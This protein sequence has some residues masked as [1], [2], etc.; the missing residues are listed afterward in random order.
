MPDQPPLAPLSLF[1]LVLFGLLLVFFVI[2]WTAL[3]SGGDARPPAR[4]READEA[5]P[6]AGAAP[7]RQAP[8][9]AK[10]AP[11]APAATVRDNAR[12]TADSDSVVSYSVRPRLQEHGE[13]RAR[14]A[15]PAA[16]A[17]PAAGWERRP[18]AAPRAAE[19]PARRP[20]PGARDVPAPAPGR[21]G[22]TRDTARPARTETGR[23]E[24]VREDRPRDGDAGLPVNPERQKSEDAFERFLRRSSD[25]HDDY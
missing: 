18:E 24:F 7:E 21:Q 19:P 20:A 1:I 16:P 4:R 3:G 13:S 8:P 10:T 2:I 14:T 5:R 15:E 9:A 17:A 11:A 23:P 12:R 22:R 25:D 6:A